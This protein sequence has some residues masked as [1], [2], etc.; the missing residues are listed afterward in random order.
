MVVLSVQLVVDLVET[1][2]LVEI[3]EGMVAAGEAMTAGLAETGEAMTVGRAAIAE[4]MTVAPVATTGDPAAIAGDMTGVPVETAGAMIR[5][6]AATVV[7]KTGNRV[8]G[9][10]GPRFRIHPNT[11]LLFRP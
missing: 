1:A 10:K 11:L 8:I 2:V 7:R 3:A 6:R 5:G 4:A 9:V